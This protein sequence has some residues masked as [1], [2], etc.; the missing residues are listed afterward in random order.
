[1]FH[2]TTEYFE[3]KGKKNDPHTTMCFLQCFPVGVFYT[4][5]V[6]IYNLACF[7]LMYDIKIIIIAFL[8]LCPQNHPL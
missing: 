4:A 7:L 8:L 6:I 2:H 3:D 1:M 5:V